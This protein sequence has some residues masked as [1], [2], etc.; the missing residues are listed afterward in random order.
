MRATIRDRREPGQ[1]VRVLVHRE[2]GALRA[3]RVHRR[4]RHRRDD[5][6][7][8]RPR[9]TRGVRASSSP[10]A[11]S[12]AELPRRVRGGA[13]RRRHRAT[14]S[15]TSTPSRTAP[16]WLGVLSHYDAVLWY[17]GDDLYVRGPDQVRPGGPDTGGTTGTEKLFDDEILNTRDYMNERRQGAGHRPAARC[18]ARGTSSSTTR[19]APR[20][21]TRSARP[22]RRPGRTTPTTRRASTTTASRCPTTS[23]STGSAP[24]CRSALDPA[25]P[26]AGGAGHR[27]HRRSCS[28]RRATSRCCT[29]S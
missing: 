25:T 9:T 20:R 8:R 18:R 4:L 29:R 6:L 15:T 13:A 24:S 19:W 2:A 16:H 12:R 23:S 14:T 22:T 21:R 5:V 28:T 17:T 27:Q 1:T 3:V 26:A 10:H 7:I 11:V